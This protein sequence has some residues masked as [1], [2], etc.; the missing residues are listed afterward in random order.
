MA[1]VRVNFEDE[2]YL[3]YLQQLERNPQR[4]FI[5]KGDPFNTL[6]EI[7]SHARFWLCTVTKSSVPFLAANKTSSR[8]ADRFKAVAHG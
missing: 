5:D 6:H 4:I 3:D 2:L 7:Q 1:V 8:V